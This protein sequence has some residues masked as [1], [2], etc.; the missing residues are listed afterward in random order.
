MQCLRYM[1]EHIKVVMFKE[2]LLLG[3]YEGAKHN[4]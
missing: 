1:G 3:V 4:S 2:M